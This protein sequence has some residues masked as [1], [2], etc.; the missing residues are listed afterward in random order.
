M[1]LIGNVS[2]FLSN[3]DIASINICLPVH[4]VH[5][6]NI[7][8]GIFSLHSNTLDLFLE[9]KVHILN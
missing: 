4:E 8:I 6:I 1:V 5:I 9:H 2:A 7:S 3:T